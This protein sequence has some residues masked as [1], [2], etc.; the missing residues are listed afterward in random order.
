MIYN[1]VAPGAAA[2]AAVTTSATKATM[3][4]VKMGASQVGRASVIEWGVS[5]N[6]SAAAA[7]FQCELIACG[8]SATVTTLAVADIINLDPLGAAVVDTFPF[9]VG[10][11][12][13]GFT[14]S[15]ASDATTPTNVRILDQQYVAPTNQYLKQ[16]PLGREPQFKPAEYLRLRVWGDGTIKVICYVVIEV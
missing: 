8:T 13:T 11:T 16:F 10:T 7:P 9:D 6:G 14:S 5:F 12:E 2:F 4:Q 15:A 3:L 1:G